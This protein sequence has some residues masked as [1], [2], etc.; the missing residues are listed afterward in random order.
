MIIF[1]PCKRECRL[2]KGL[3]YYTYQMYDITG[4]NKQVAGYATSGLKTGSTD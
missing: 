1:H 4:K 2:V 3:A